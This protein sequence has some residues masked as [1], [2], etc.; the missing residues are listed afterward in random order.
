MRTVVPGHTEDEDGALKHPV[1]IAVDV[2]RGR[3]IV[4]DSHHHC[5]RCVDLSTGSVSTLAG[6][7]GHSGK[8]DGPGQLARF[9]HPYVAASV[10]VSFAAVAA[11]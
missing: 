11:V 6:A 7:V 9:C 8:T 10:I 4:G 1:G 5:V 2:A 3:L